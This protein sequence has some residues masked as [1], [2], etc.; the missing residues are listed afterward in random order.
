MNPEDVAGLIA[1]SSILV[2]LALSVIGILIPI[3]AYW[4]ILDKAGHPGPLALLFLLPFVG[5]IMLYWLA[6]AE[7]PSLR[8]P[9][10]PAPVGFPPPPVYPPAPPP[11]PPVVMPAAPAAALPASKFCTG[12][13]TAL[14]GVERFC[15]N[16]GRPVGT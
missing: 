14:E 6:L 5:I 7:W 10:A 15:R 16:C 2:I 1:G 3:V 8:R 4:K 11:P 12:C 13:G 9:A